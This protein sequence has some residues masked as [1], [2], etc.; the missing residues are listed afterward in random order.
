MR[1]IAVFAVVS[2]ICLTL[3]SACISDAEKKPYPIDAY[4]INM[5]PKVFSITYP[6]IYPVITSYIF[7][8][9]SA[10]WDKEYGYVFISTEPSFFIGSEYLLTHP[11]D[12]VDSGDS[13][14]GNMFIVFSDSL[15]D[16]KYFKIAN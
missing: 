14:E 3:I 15:P 9:K 7:K 11:D 13:P 5:S 10:K 16:L 8:S 12:A 2:I 1:K 4:E 6:E